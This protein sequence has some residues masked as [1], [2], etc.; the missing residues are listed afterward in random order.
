MA[1]HEEGLL[2][3]EITVVENLDLSH[4]FVPNESIVLVKHKQLGLRLTREWH[5]FKVQFLNF[6]ES[7]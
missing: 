4:A 5:T 6:Q 3:S 1:R 2:N 7:H